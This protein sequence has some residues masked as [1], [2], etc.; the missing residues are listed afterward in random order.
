LENQ[1]LCDKKRGMGAGQLLN[2]EGAAYGARRGISGVGYQFDQ[3]FC[4]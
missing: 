2:K 1:G 4:C 3:G